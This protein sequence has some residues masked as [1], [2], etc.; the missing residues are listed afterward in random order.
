MRLEQRPKQ[1][2]ECKQAL[3]TLGHRRQG[4]LGYFSNVE[5]TLTNN[6][7]FFFLFFCSSQLL[8]QF[9]FCLFFFDLCI[10]WGVPSRLEWRSHHSKAN[11]LRPSWIA[12]C[13]PKIHL[14]RTYLRNGKY[15]TWVLKVHQPK[16]KKRK[17][18]FRDINGIAYTGL[19]L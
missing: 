14:E 9:R 8:L 10:G 3:L 13:G 12:L 18:R 5:L 7:H 15:I 16:Q 1:Y 2:D 19:K 4:S 11:F 6:F 17:L